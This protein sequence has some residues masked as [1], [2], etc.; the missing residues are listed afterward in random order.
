MVSSTRVKL[1][2]VVTLD[3]YRQDGQPSLSHH[4]DTS[5]R[6]ERIKHIN[7]RQPQATSSR[8]GFGE[9]MEVLPEHVWHAGL[10][11][12]PLLVFPRYRSIGGRER[13]L[14]L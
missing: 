4:D 12:S 2:V 1:S 5:E 9:D 14:L 11:Q 10:C 3:H 13:C 8:Q 6:A 7:T